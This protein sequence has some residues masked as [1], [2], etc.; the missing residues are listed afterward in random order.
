MSFIKETEN[1]LVNII[2][3]CGYEVD[4]V[5]LESS[6]RRDL[7]EFQINVAMSLAK[8][9]GKNPRDIANEIVS[10]LDDRFCNVNLAGPGFINV[11][12]SENYLIDKMNVAG[13]DFL[14]LLDEQEEK[15]I[16]IDYGGANAAKALH[17]GHMR[18]ANIG[19]SLKR[20]SNLVGNNTIGDVHLGDLGRQSGMVISEI[21]KR[22]PDL[23]Y[24]DENYKGQYPKLEITNEELEIYETDETISQINKELINNNIKVY[25]IYE[26][27][28]TL[29]DQFFEMVN[30]DKVNNYNNVITNPLVEGESLIWSAKPK[31][32]A[33]IINKVLI[34]MPF[35]LLWLAFDSFF[36][37]SMGNVGNMLYF[38]VPFFALHLMPLKILLLTDNAV[39]VHM[40]KLLK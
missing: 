40:H 6:S 18:A 23:C 13:S 4:N 27:N 33:F 39:L 31:K 19:E 16:I 26:N 22:K 29:E 35:A 3:E 36:I 30:N 37:F 25:R 12:I 28:K 9:Y 15:T 17:V 10:K 21:K 20:L 8:K 5:S 7:G 32:S 14:S 34:M 11:S 38:L 24:F 2:K 1:Y